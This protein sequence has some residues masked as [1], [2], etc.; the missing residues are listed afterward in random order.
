MEKKI[1]FDEFKRIM[2]RLCY[3]DEYNEIEYDRILSIIGVYNGDLAMEEYE[4]KS[5]S[6]YDLY[7]Y[8]HQVIYDF[9]DSKGYIEH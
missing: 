6:L 1:T 9:L 3:V 7:Q 2:E 5:N 8:R 4:K